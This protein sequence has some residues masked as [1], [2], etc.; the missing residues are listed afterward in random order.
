MYIYICI[1]IGS[2]RKVASPP[3][4]PCFPMSFF[5]FRPHATPNTL[6]VRNISPPSQTNAPP[7]SKR[8]SSPPCGALVVLPR[9]VLVLL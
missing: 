8:P 4:K 9:P 5:S 3:L 6:L 1:H 2:T 7:S